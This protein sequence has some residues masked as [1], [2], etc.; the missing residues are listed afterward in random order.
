MPKNRGANILNNWITFENVSWTA[1][2]VSYLLYLLYNTSIIIFPGCLLGGVSL[3]IHI[4]GSA[5]VAD[6][7]SINTTSYNM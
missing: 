3:S 5:T 2:I 6:E 7:Y 4:H 1:I